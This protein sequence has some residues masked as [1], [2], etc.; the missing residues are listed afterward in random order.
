MPAPRKFDREKTASI[1][2][3]AATLGLPLS[4]TLQEVLDVSHNQARHMIRMARQDGFLGR[5]GHAPARAVIHRGSAREHS[6]LACS[7]CLHP[8]PCAGSA[9]IIDEEN[10]A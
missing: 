7:T 5:N 8:W 1:V 10:D 6:Y 4:K 9:I 2:L 3:E